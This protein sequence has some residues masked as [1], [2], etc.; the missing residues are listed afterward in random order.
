MDVV[1]IVLLQTTQTPGL[2]PAELE[3]VV[4]DLVRAAWFV[5]GLAVVVAVGWFVVEPAISRVVRRRNRG[6]ATLQ[7][8]IARYVR[9]VVVVLGGLLGAVF[10]G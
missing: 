4:P 7:E 5:A 1:A 3:D 9:L 2:G 8:A 6:N 10:A